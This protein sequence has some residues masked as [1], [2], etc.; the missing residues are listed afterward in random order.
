MA[1]FTL[2]IDDKGLKAGFV[3]FKKANTIAVRN[4]L[5]I[6]AALSRKNYIRNM[7]NEFT[8][9][10]T[11]TRRSIQFDKADQADIFLMESRV[12]S[13]AEYMALQEEGGRKRPKKGTRLAI[14]ERPA[15]G[16]SS[17][18]VIL[19]SNYLRRMK[20]ASMVSG[21]F[22]KSYSSRKARAVARMAI[23]FKTKKFIKKRDGIYV[24]KSFRARNGKV[25]V[26]MSRI[27]SLTQTSVRIKPTHLLERSIKKPVND[28]PNIHKSQI[29]RLFRSAT[30]I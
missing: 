8:T 19:R 17:A 24:V 9:R 18:S 25:K 21:S 5:N 1:D 12:G 20:N 28:G 2:K 23:G 7:E 14:G 6:Q 15:R 16:G 10:N 11:F 29:K 27:Y 30:I 22:K 26:R 3:D 4:T 13:K